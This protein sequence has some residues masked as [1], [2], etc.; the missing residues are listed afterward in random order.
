MF[1]IDNHLDEENVL[2]EIKL[3]NGVDYE[4]IK[5]ELYERNDDGSIKLDEET[6]RRIVATNPKNIDKIV[7]LLNI[8]A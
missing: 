2:P 8:S 3:A 4:K 5:S 1:K 7:L 6:G